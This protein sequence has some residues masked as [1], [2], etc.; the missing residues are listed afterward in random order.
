[1]KKTRAPASVIDLT[2]ASKAQDLEPRPYL[3]FRAT[4]L[5]ATD[6]NGGVL[7]QG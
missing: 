5:L 2:E 4:F 7:K 6:L 1:M 3:V